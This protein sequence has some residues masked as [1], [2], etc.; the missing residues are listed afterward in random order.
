M[1]EK[2]FKKQKLNKNDHKKQDDNAKVVR[3][4]LGAFTFLAPL[5]IGVKKYGPK[6]VKEI[7]SIIRKV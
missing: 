1:A 4:G 6:V 7:A 5:A 3:N 2:Q